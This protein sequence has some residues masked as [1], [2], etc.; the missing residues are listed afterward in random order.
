[1]QKPARSK[2]EKRKNALTSCVL[3]HVTIANFRGKK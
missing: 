2:G 1:M 3:P